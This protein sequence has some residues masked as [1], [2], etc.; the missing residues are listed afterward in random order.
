MYK[1]SVDTKNSWILKIHIVYFL[2]HLSVNLYN[3][4]MPGVLDIRVISINPFSTNSSIAFL[5][6]VLLFCVG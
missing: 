6:V 3:V 5:N 4:P 1:L 2:C